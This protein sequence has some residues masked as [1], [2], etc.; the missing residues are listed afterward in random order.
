MSGRGRGRRTFSLIELVV[1]TAV[2]TV[3]L[4]GVLAAVAA[5][6]RARQV[7][8]ET[9]A[10]TRALQ[11]LS[12][13]LRALG[14]AAAVDAAQAAPGWRPL[15]PADVA[16]GGPFAGLPTTTERRVEVLDEAAATAA[17]GLAAA[18][19]DLD[20]DGTP[21]EEGADSAVADYRIAPLRLSVRWPQPGGGA[22]QLD[23]LTVLYPREAGE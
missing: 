20:R 18:P 9:E 13:A 15:D 17:L 12:E 6:G 23:T 14:P 16:P 22:R 21:G 3:A 2:L 1:A 4:L 5:A 10:A 19:L 11:D 8:G 7:T